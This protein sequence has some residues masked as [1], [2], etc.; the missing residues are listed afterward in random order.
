MCRNFLRQADFLVLATLWLTG[1]SGASR[2]D[3][4]A[5]V[6]CDGTVE[7]NGKPLTNAQVVFIPEAGTVGPGGAAMT[8][9]S[10]YY[11]VLSTGADRQPAP[12]L[13]PGK[14]KVIFSRMVLPDGNVWVPDPD[15]SEGPATRGARE[16]LPMQYSMAMNSK[17]IVDV[18]D[19]G[20]SL[21]FTLKKKR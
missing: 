6:A 2:P 1:C 5:P 10:G 4:P 20:P 8:D 12:G 17:F 9:D 7:L 3:W 11:S 18:Q 19:G 21:D 16:E 14:Y 13:I 15:V